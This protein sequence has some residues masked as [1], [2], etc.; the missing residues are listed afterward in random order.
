MM[1]DRIK[2]MFD[3]MFLPK[4]IPQEVLAA[5]ERATFLM[6]KVDAPAFNVRDLCILAGCA[7]ANAGPMEA[8]TP[9]ARPELDV[10]AMIPI[11]ESPHQPQAPM[12]QPVGGVMDTPPVSTEKTR[13]TTVTKLMTLT[14]NEL[15]AH[16]ELLN[17]SMPAGL[18]KVN[19]I[20]FIIG[21][22]F[23]RPTR[24]SEKAPQTGK[25]IPKGMAESKMK[26]MKIADLRK[27]ALELYGFKAPKN[28]SVTTLAAVLQTKPLLEHEE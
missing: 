6:N 14:E 25:R 16:A 2:E 23:Q 5:Y 15:K 24:T 28:Y 22:P 10:S 8:I 9:P 27:H 11:A 17:L 19:Q 4:P 3:R 12:T 26:K 20:R 7:L 13:S 1:N 21:E 18:D